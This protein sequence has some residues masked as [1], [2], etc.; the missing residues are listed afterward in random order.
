MAF[1]LKVKT[2]G[3]FYAI[4]LPVVTEAGSTQVFK[5]EFKFKRVSR[6]KLND[7]TRQ[8][9]ELN[10]S[11]IEVDS[12]ERDTDW[13]ME[14]AEGW[15]YVEDEAGKEVPFN[16][17]SVRMLLNSY[18]NASGVIGTAFFQATMGGGKKGN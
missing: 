6:A 10:K 7:L 2:E 1:V 17:E 15:R 13:V 8:Q 11:D 9:E 12:L 14:I 16:R 3:F 18:P 5:F 4:Q